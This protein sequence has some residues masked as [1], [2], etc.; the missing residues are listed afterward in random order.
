METGELLLKF[1]LKEPTG[2]VTGAGF[3]WPPPPSQ[4]E[5]PSTMPREINAGRVRLVTGNPRFAPLPTL[6]AQE[7]HEGLLRTYVLVPGF[8]GP[9]RLCESCRNEFMAK[10]LAV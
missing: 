8:K 9:L 5:I 7:R 4:A 3:T 10:S 6:N 2:A 1:G